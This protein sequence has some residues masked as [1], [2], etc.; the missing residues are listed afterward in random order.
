MTDIPDSDFA[1]ARSEETTATE[2]LPENHR[3]GYV[4]VIGRPNVG[5]STLI[6]ALLG[7]KIAIVSPRP[8]T[9]RVRQLGILTRDDAQAVFMDTPGLHK[10]RHPLGE[11]MVQ[12]AEEA[13]ADSDLILFV[14][15][16]SGPPEPGD[17]MITERIAAVA[18]ETPVILAL[19]K[20]DL[21]PPEKLQAH[22][23]AYLELVRPTDW[24][25]LS[26]LHTRGVDDLRERLIGQLPPGPRYFPPDEI[27][28][29]HLRNIAAELIREQVLLHTR[30]EVPHAVAVEIE[31]Y[32][33]REDGL[34]AINATIY[35]ERDSQKGIIIGKGGQMLKRIGSAARAE[36]EALVGA[37]VFLQL[38]VK[39]LPN[40]R[41]DEDMLRRLGYR[42]NR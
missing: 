29:L 22:V 12:V 38:W 37:R 7:Q 35:A 24:V 14:V 39:V 26:A 2:D 5:K 28:D 36:I 33:E 21:T 18:P 3:S 31:E 9:T 34:H 30:D 17:Q 16:V 19:N 41:Q 13:L 6:N 1:D 27:S 11:F 20:I 23:N 10:P 15:D 25:A 8:Q 32:T 42:V 4:A 40:W